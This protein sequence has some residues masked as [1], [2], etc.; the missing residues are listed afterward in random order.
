MPSRA[1]ALADQFE[2]ATNELIAEVEACPEDRWKAVTPN[3]GRTFNVVAHHVAMGDVP[4]AGFVGSIANGEGLPNVTPEMIDQGNAEHAKQQADVSKE[5]V[6]ADLRQNCA[7]AVALVR[8]LNDEQLDQSGSA[9]GR[10]WTT[11]QVIEMVL[12]GHTQD[13]LNTIRATTG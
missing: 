6:I 4:I 13:H 9:F 7:S 11:Q 12:I 10:D 8:G 3:D 1:E 2:A 5:Q